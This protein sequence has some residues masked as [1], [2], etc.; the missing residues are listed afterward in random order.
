MTAIRKCMTFSL[1]LGLSGLFI[2]FLKIN[3]TAFSSPHHRS[4]DASASQDLKSRLANGSL[5]HVPAYSSS[6]ASQS[7]LTRGLVIPR[8]EGDNVTWLDTITTN[9]EVTVYVANNSSAALHPPTNKGN[10]AMMYLTHLIDHYDSLPDILIFMHSHLHAHHNSEVFDLDAA[11]MLLH[12]QDSHILNQGYFNLRCDWSPGC[13]DWLD[14]L[15]KT[16]SLA[17][18]E[19]ALLAESWHELFPSHP[20]PTNLAQP[21]CA[22]FAVSKSR[23]LSVPRSRYVYYRDW[24]LMTPLSDY[25][26][27]RIWEYSWQYVFTGQERYCPKESVCYCEGF[28]VCFEAEGEYAVFK[29]MVGRRKEI[30]ERLEGVMVDAGDGE[31]DFVDGESGEDVELIRERLASIELEVMELRDGALQRGLSL[32]KGKR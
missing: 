14:P 10:E 15:I 11:T 3:T 5:S 19:Q 26:S 6:L 20:L 27:G 8:L 22:Q 4:L 13:P 2:F 9:H 18:Q 32:G 30:R 7:N 23:I 1:L 24:L 16:E 29:E 21:C 12:L 31:G 17:K 28:G 25:V